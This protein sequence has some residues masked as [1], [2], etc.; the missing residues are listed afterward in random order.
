MEDI[1]ASI[2]AT[3]SVFK[4]SSSTSPQAPPSPMPTTWSTKCP[5]NGNTLLP[6]RSS[7]VDEETA[8]AVILELG[9]R[10]DK[11]QTPYILTKGLVEVMPIMCS[12]KCSCPEPSPIA[13]S[14]CSCG[15]YVRHHC[16]SLYGVGRR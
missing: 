15:V 16:H 8:P 6:A 13:Q 5:N 14:H 2:R 3:T 1:S 4:S 9:D 7:Y 12:T 10:E 11:D